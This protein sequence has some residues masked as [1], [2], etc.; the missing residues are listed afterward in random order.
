M[1]LQRGWQANIDMQIEGS[2]TGI[3]SKA[4]HSDQKKS[5][6]N[7]NIEE[8]LSKNNYDMTGMVNENGVDVGKA[9]SSSNNGG[10]DMQSSQVKANFGHPQND[11]ENHS[12]SGGTNNTRDKSQSLSS[13]MNSSKST[14]TA[15]PPPPPPPVLKG[16]LSYNEM[17]RR[18]IL[19][20]MWNYEAST[21]FPAQRFELLRNLGP[22][23]DPTILPADG[24]FHGSFSLAYY[25]TTSKGKR[26]ERSKVIPEKD[27]NITFKKQGEKDTY[28]VNG[29]G[30]N[31]FGIFQI[32]G[33]AVKD[34]FE[35]DKNFKVELRKKYITAPSSSPAAP[36]KTKSKN[37]KRKRTN[38]L[39][40]DVI[41]S[42]AE[43]DGP[44]PPPS[45]TFESHVYCLR[46]KLTRDSSDQNG[47]SHKVSGLWSSGLD[48]IEAD[49][50]NTRGLCNVFEY[51]HRC[52]L[53]TQSF[54]LSG[55]YTGWFNLTNED[56]SRT[57][58]SER[59]VTL[60]FRKNNAGYYN[61]EGKG[62]NTFGK[63]H[64][65]GTLDK[66]NVITIFRHFQARKNKNSAMKV[67]ENTSSM[68]VHDASSLSMTLKDVDV[69]DKDLYEP[70]ELPGDGFFAAVSR[71][72]LKVN[73]D[74]S[75]TCTGKWATTS[76]QL[77]TDGGSNFHFGLESHHA[78]TAIEEMKASF[79]VNASKDTGFPLD[80]AHYKGS[81]KMKRGTAKLQPFID[82]QIVLKFRKNTSGSYN[83]YG[84]GVNQIGIFSM[85]GNLVPTGGG[86]GG[87]VVLYRVYETIP[88]PQ[89]KT[90]TPAQNNRG[91]ALPLSKKIS[92]RSDDG[93]I[94]GRDPSEP[95]AS[96]QPSFNASSL[97]V[98]G[99]R[100]STR[101]TKLPSRLEADD[102][103]AQKARMMDKCR[104]ILKHLLDQDKIA[105]SFFTEPVDPVAHGI[106]T[107][108]QIIVNPMDLGTIQ[109]MMNTD[110][111]DTP[112]EFA[113]L[114][115]LV[116]ENAMKF[117]VDHTHF[118]HQ[119]ARN[120]LII[121]NQKYR[122]VERMMEKKKPSKAEMKEIKRKQQR[123]EKKRIDDEKKRKREENDDPHKRKFAL[124]QASAQEVKKTLNTLT[125]SSN[126]VITR[127]E[128]NLLLNTM[129]KMQGQIAEISDVLSISLNGKD[130][131]STKDTIP[132]IPSSN[133]SDAGNE[134]KSKKKAPKSQKKTTEAP[135]PEA[136]TLP[137]SSSKKNEEVPLTIEEQED[138]TST[139]NTMLGDE[140]KLQAII[141]II[142]ESTALNG[143]E[144]EIDLEI[145]QLNTATQRKLQHYVMKHKPKAKRGSKKGQRKK[146][147]DTPASLPTIESPSK[148]SPQSK[149]KP[150]TNSSFFGGDSDDS[151]SESDGE[152][153]MN[154][155]ELS[156]KQQ[157]LKIGDEV[158]YDE[159]NEEDDEGNNTFAGWS[160]SKTAD[161]EPQNDDSG[162]EDDA[163][164]AALDQSKEQMLLE[165]DRIAREEK[166]IADA[167][168][169][170]DKQLKEAE[171]RANK[172]KRDRKA[173]EDEE[174]RKRQQQENEE[175][176]RAEEIKNRTIQEV[177]ATKAH[178]DLGDKQRDIIDEYEKSLYDKDLGGGASPS[179]DFGF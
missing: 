92:H 121:F 157:G 159:D 43:D 105:G 94:G 31:E 8:S 114:A 24:E 47:V 48:L 56:G 30:M 112:E 37:K 91:K 106:P 115:R 55:R 62:S 64:L 98:G 95:Q 100:E 119:S 165:K 59:D 14:A 3:S 108:N 73:E 111:I 167:K 45:E 99:R 177:I 72:V 175:L 125:A 131:T 150:N 86:G 160:M 145:N 39:E 118:V 44:L 172:I 122:D 171:E 20:G 152:I 34:E 12:A 67:V 46:G 74:G 4:S 53:P 142:R 33:T 109:D 178:V 32:V 17:A 127:D 110:K 140:E 149:S 104:S 139:I 52:T 143:D 13:E 77:N 66:E 25:H 128:F 151:D 170:K 126:N 60:K 50:Q 63:Y 146:A 158:Q 141:D 75:H 23:E 58:I 107:Y 78:V 117:N 1:P 16:T 61:V 135:N 5:T 11:T 49:P 6:Q 148:P 179:S 10:D 40:D 76:S 70:V 89:Q 71:G 84:K 155:E 26:K 83:V 169:A 168:A 123:E 138:L 51:E 36:K 35:E 174:L 134:K 116:F 147:N 18:H 38:E 85:V 7:K 102:P 90:V 28:D 136:T 130:P 137:P 79:K 19:R 54:P 101:A 93:K 164:L 22:D 57:R 88:D 87:H 97:S 129:Q 27:V 161:P 124:V 176:K 166:V 120:L 132:N 154:N 29:Q 81:F 162:E 173:E 15:Q 144:E 153:Q 21:E 82:N 163:W 113:R 65:S 96:T 41:N 68:G 9:K 103:Q 2:A 69:P 42:V 80:S 156:E 133:A